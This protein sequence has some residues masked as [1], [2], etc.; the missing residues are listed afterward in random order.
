LSGGTRMKLGMLTQLG[1]PTVVVIASAGN[2]DLPL[3]QPALM[4]QD[5][6][7]VTSIPLSIR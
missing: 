5:M 1:S 6:R 4:I 3:H 7:L 2:G